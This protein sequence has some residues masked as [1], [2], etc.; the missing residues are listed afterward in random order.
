MQP[1]SLELLRSWTTCL[2]EASNVGEQG[3]AYRRLCGK[4]FR[5]L[6][7]IF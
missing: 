6:S 2:F 5:E 4:P 7:L 1:S 3:I